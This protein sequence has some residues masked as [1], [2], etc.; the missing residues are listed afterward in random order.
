MEK[1]LLNHYDKEYLKIVMLKHE[2][3]F[4]EQV[5]ELHRLYQIQ[6]MLMMKD[7]YKLTTRRNDS[8]DHAATCN[9]AE[10]R[11]LEEEIKLAEPDENYRVSDEDDDLELTLGPRSYY[12]YYQKKIKGAPA[13]PA[14]PSDDS[15]PSFSSSSTGSSGHMRGIT[16]NTTTTRDRFM[17]EQPMPSNQDRLDSP[18]WPLQALCNMT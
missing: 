8:S 15:W 9:R 16:R 4:R 3:T 6:K 17:S 14:V 2:E 5:Y 13:V 11:V 7:M 18:P 12:Y 1:L 10:A